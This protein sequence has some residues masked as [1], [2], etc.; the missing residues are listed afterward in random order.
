MFTH[1]HGLKDAARRLRQEMTDA[2]QCLWKHLRRKQIRGV[3]FLRQRPIGPYVVDFYCAQAKLVVEV[4]GGQHYSDD[5]TRA[6]LHRDDF[7][8]RVGLEVL[9]FDNRQVLTSTKDVLEQIA[10]RVEER[11]EKL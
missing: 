6:D 10:R 9:R 11:L 7:L 8:R 5:G 3:P 1:K 2:E 4:D